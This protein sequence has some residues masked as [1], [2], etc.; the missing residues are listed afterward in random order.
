MTEAR[1][2]PRVSRRT[3]LLPVVALVIAVVIVAACFVASRISLNY[4]V[5]SPG[6][7]Q[8]V[9]PL[10][11]VPADRAHRI[12]GPVLLTDVY[13][14]PVTAL[15]YLFDLV[16]Q[17]DQLVPTGAL[18]DPGIPPSELTAQGY[19][20][21]VQAKAAAETAALRRVGY[22]I[23]EH[24]AGAVL[25]GV[26]SGTPAFGVLRVGQVVTAV[27]GV[28][29]QTSCD[30]VRR[31]SMFGPGQSVRLSVRENRFSPAG[32]LVDGPVVTKVV[33]LAKRPADDPA[34]S[35]CTAR[36]S[37][38][39]LGV[40]A[41]TQ[42]DFTYPFPI[43]INTADIGGPSAGLAMTLGLVNTLSGG[44]LTG[45]RIVAAT[46]TIDQFG[47]VGD[48]GGVPQKTIAVERAGATVFFVPP[49]ELAAA[50]SKATP[51]LHIYAVSTLAQALSILKKLGGHVPATASQ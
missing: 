28:A 11:K 13:L 1:S 9:G 25:V 6:D 5:L 37:A 48:V 27:D 36:P 18:V 17:N 47:N 10:I 19:L 26:V 24:D 40:E 30:F 33:R 2:E 7:A 20:E 12:D 31:L 16:S 23:A 15:S 34:I 44:H 22:D 39:F 51:S 29:T 14:S 32:V 38:G 46:G 41:Q 45:G 49:P 8:S 50:R 4:F 42:Q 35:G 21:M 3:N 43:T